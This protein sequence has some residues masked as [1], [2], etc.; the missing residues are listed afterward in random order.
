VQIERGDWRRVL[1][2]YGHADALVYAD[3]PYVWETR[4][5]DKR[6]AHEARRIT[7]R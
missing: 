1:A 2:A 5:G 3:P 7:R 4:R 6:Y